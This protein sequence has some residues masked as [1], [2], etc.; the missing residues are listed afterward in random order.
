MAEK[1]NVIVKRFVYRTTDK[2]KKSYF[3]ESTELP[4]SP[5]SRMSTVSR[6]SRYVPRP[7]TQHAK[8]RASNYTESI[9][10][11]NNSSIYVEDLPKTKTPSVVSRPM[12]TNQEYSHDSDTVVTTV[13][14]T[15]SVE[16]AAPT[17][18]SRRVVVV[19]NPK[20]MKQPSQPSDLE[21]ISTSYRTPDVSDGVS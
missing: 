18:P 9:E 20:T 12:K 17:L 3:V 13:D 10:T 16:N 7:I 14:E 11:M 6:Q 21:S 19:R 4:P 1:T 2:Q 15:P 5:K 8:S